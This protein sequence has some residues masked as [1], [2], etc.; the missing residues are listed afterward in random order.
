MS[1]FRSISPE[2][3]DDQEA[4]RGEYACWLEINA[5]Q[6]GLRLDKQEVGDQAVWSLSSAKQGFGVEQLRDDNIE[7]C[8]QSDGAQPHYINIQFHK[9]MTLQEIRIYADYKVDESYTPH[10]I[11]I[12]SGTT[13]HDLKEVQQYEVPTEEGGWMTIPLHP[14]NSPSVP[15]RSNLIQIAI[16]TNHQNGRDTHVRQVKIFSPIQR[17]HEAGPNFTDDFLN[18]ST[19][20]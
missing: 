10:N 18:F 11:S 1:Y 8:W 7:T 4:F 14:P 9:R 13:F 3:A 15:L 5:I 12:R 2:R 6:A 17:T 19:M 20:R 16:L